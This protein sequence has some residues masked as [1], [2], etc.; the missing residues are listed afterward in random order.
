MNGLKPPKFE[1]KNC[2]LGHL[3]YAFLPSQPIWALN[4]EINKGK[5]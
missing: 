2:D 3:E 5:V 4:L 1:E